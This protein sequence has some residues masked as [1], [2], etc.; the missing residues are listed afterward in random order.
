[1]QVPEYQ[2]LT[3]TC[4]SRCGSGTYV[5]L[6][7]GITPLRLYYRVRRAYS[8]AV[9]APVRSWRAQGSPSALRPRFPWW[10]SLA[11]RYLRVSTW[12]WHVRFRLR[13]AVRPGRVY[14]VRLAQ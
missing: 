8:L 7:V 5:S 9:W 4:R 13:R 14:Y 1:M 10:S 2:L 6:G 11:Y 12:L 3:Q